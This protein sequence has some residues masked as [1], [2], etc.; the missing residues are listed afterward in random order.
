MCQLSSGVLIIAALIGVSLWPIL[1]FKRV[2]TLEAALDWDLLTQSVSDVPLSNGLHYMGAPWHA[3]IKYPKT[4][5]NM[6]FSTADTPHDELHCRTVDGLEVVLEV[7]FQYQF[8]VDELH[9]LYSDF[10]EDGYYLVYF[11]VASHMIAESAADYT[12]YQFFNSKEAIALAM[13][14]K[15]DD[16]F[17]AHL[18]ATIISLQIQNSI[19]PEAFNDAITDTVTQRQNI[20]NAEKY[21]EQMEVLLET[22]IIVAE[23]SANMTLAMAHGQATQIGLSAEAA[24]V[25]YSQN[26]EAEAA[27]YK[28]VKRQLKLDN[29]ELLQ[30]VWWDTVE[31]STSDDAS[32][33]VGVSPST[34]L[35]T[36]SPVT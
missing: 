19:L 17:S 18:H 27:A 15:L 22:Q 5:Q 25:V 21:M 4:M 28:N 8:I 30:Y 7:T 26:G 12:A 16:Y 36:S 13:T 6:Q 3:L 14:E 23:K 20:T 9:A 35:R 11:D 31:G 2:H 29:D 33:L 1:S 32:L 34:L 10:G 24:S